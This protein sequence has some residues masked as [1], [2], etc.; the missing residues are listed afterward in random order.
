MGV[1]KST[2]VITGGPC[3]GKT[4]TILEVKDYLESLGY[5][6]LLLNEC[7]TE[8]I[9]AGIKPFGENQVSVFDFQNEVFNL[10][11][12]KEKRYL[13]IIEKLPKESKVIMLL[14]RGILDSKA[15]L[16]DDKLWNKLLDMNNVKEEELGNNYDLIL[17]LETVALGIKDEY[18]L[19]SNEARFEDTN[20]AISVDNRIKK[21][22]QNSKSL[23]VIKPTEL[24]E[25][26]VMLIKD[27][28]KEFLEK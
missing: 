17:D 27:I 19:T 7:A 18:N 12:Y 9:L 14:D 23:K 4:V 25:E 3:A 15:Y 28:I 21:V 20:D 10:Q 26:K 11:R 13:D 6:V 1:L 22:Y 2:I 24:V 8:L 5:Q 16:N